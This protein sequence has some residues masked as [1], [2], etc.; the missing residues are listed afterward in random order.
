M[1]TTEPDSTATPTAAEAPA[2]TP[3]TPRTDIYF[4][5]RRFAPVLVVLF[6]IG[7]LVL[8]DPTSSSRSRSSPTRATPLPPTSSSMTAVAPMSC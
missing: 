4:R 3:A 7:V 1:P 2:A 5:I 6:C 8:R